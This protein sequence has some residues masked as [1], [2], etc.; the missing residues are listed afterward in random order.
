MTKDIILGKITYT[1]YTES[2]EEFYWGCW[3]N[4]NGDDHESS[5]ACSSELDA[6]E[7]AEWNARVDYG[8]KYAKRGK[9]NA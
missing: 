2:E 5:K 8:Y 6:I 4:S 9:G 1:L 7:T 3:T